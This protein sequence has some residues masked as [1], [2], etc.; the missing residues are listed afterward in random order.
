MFLAAFIAKGAKATGI[1]ETN[2]AVIPEC[3]KRQ[4]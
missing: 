2:E 4:R 3:F 1:S